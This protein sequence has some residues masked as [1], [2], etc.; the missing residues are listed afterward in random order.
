MFSRNSA[1]SRAI[2]VNKI[3]SNIR[4]EPAKPIYWGIN[5]KGMQASEELSDADIVKAESIWLAS[6]ESQ[7]QFAEQLL[8]LNVHKQIANRLLEC[9]SH[10]T[11]IL[12]ATDFGNF[13]NLRAHKD[14]QPEFQELAHQML[15]LY[16]THIPKEL[17]AGQWHTP[18]SDKYVEKG[19]SLV[20]LLKIT[21]A[22][23][24]R[25]SYLNF[26]GDIAFD[27]DYKLHDDLVN[28]GHWSPFEHA[29]QATGDVEYHGNFKGFKQYRKL[30]SA[31]NKRLYDIIALRAGRKHYAKKNNMEKVDRPVRS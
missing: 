8:A 14:A 23:C 2:P 18:F 17:K 25:V 13:F 31:E 4:A 15:D 27:K 20:N 16:E 22:R 28:S 26:E 29:A 7:I 1:S 21:T 6:M 11:V 5:Q 10:M 9:Y 24:A 12:S 19:V 30:F 3:I